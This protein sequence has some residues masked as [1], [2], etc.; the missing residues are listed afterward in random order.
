[1]ASRSPSTE[2]WGVVLGQR[3]IQTVSQQEHLF[4][5]LPRC[6]IR[7]PPSI[8]AI[9]FTCFISTSRES[10]ASSTS[11]PFHPGRRIELDKKERSTKRGDLLFEQ[12]NR[13]STAIIANREMTEVGWMLSCLPA[14]LLS[15]GVR[16]LCSAASEQE[17]GRGASQ[18]GYTKGDQ[19][20]SDERGG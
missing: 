18:A 1:M 2:S 17:A 8:P 7:I 4:R 10:L 19:E 3:E 6:S 12:N 13:D 5:A 16:S 11:R 20:P 9:D 14:C 15:R